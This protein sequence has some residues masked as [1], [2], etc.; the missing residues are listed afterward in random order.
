MTGA[1]ATSFS[2]TGLVVGQYYRYASAP[3]CRGIGLVEQRQ[4]RAW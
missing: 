3:G 4:G 1:N 2:D